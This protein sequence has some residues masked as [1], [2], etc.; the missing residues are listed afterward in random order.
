MRNNK[1]NTKRTFVAWLLLT[2]FM[3]PMVTKAV[4]VCH[5]Q[6]VATCENAKATTHHADSCSICHFAFLTFDKAENVVLGVLIAIL[7]YALP[8]FREKR[9]AFVHLATVSLRAP[10]HML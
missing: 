2:L 9:K 8:F 7:A 1:H 5:I 4:H 6:H 3:L 10:P